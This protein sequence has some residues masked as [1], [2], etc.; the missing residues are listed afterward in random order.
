MGRRLEPKQ[1]GSTIS[2]TSITLET[3]LAATRFG[4][5]RARLGGTWPVICFRAPDHQQLADM[6]D[7]R[8][9]EQF[10]ERGKKLFTSLPV[11]VIDTNLDQFM[12]GEI[13][14]DL[15]EH[16]LRETIL[17]DRDYRIQGMSAGAQSAQ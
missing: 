13:R 8:S 5:S 7:R 3:A 6:L 12:T 2:V 16:G 11:I 4:A 14:V 9:V 17:A 1:L 15:P 10:A